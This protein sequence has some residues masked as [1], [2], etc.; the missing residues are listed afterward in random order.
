MINEKKF[1]SLQILNF[2]KKSFTVKF[3]VSI[4]TMEIFI[5]NDCSLPLS[6]KLSFNLE[7][8][9][10][11]NKFFKQFES[12]EE[13]F[14]FIVG[15]DELDQKISVVTEE[16]FAKL[17]ISL[18]IISKGYS[19]NNIELMVPIVEVKENDLIVKLCEK[20][21]KLN[22]IELKLKYILSCLSKTEEDF[23][24]YAETLFYLNKNI[25]NIESKIITVD[26]FVVPAIGIKTKLNKKIK[27]VKLLYRAS[28]DGDSTQFH[29]KCNG[30]T[31]TITFVKAINGRKFGGFASLGWHSNNSWM[32]DKN[33][34]VFSLNSKECFYYVSGNG[35]YGSSS[36][37]PLWGP[38]HD[39]YL[40][41]GC[42]SNNSSTTN[43]SASYNYNGKTLTLSGGSNFQAEDY[44]TYECIFE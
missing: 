40:A 36:Y 30:K 16:N 41:S 29:N 42:L 15:L 14:D 32:Q 25:K 24:I 26:D 4:N 12:I 18:P 33:A 2:D 43:Q 28:R 8:F 9:H 17:T 6:Y 34:F 31:N 35:I 27:E 37:G 5:S 22:I 1:H 20:A 13:V 7:N 11:L 39:L 10:K 23:N 21:E 3:S 44:E 19:Y 38:G